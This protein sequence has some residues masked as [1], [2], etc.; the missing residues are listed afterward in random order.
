MQARQ[1]ARSQEKIQHP[2]EYYA[3]AVGARPGIY[4][5]WSAAAK[6]VVGFTGAVYKGFT[7]LDKARAF[8]SAHHARVNET[9]PPPVPTAEYAKHC[10]CPCPSCPYSSGDIREQRIALVQRL[11]QLSKREQP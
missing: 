6:Q 11:Y 10:H 1:Q 3:V 8:M 4:T 7:T 2:G 9:V 5:L